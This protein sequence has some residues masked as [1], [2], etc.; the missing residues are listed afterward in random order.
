MRSNLQ[1]AVMAG[2][3]AL[4]C[5]PM[6]AANGVDRH[7][8]TPTAAD[9]PIR[10][11][12]IHWNANYTATTCC[13]PSPYRHT[14]TYMRVQIRVPD[15]MKPL[16][17]RWPKL[18]VL[19]T[20]LGVVH[21]T[22]SYERMYKLGPG[23]WVRGYGW[24]TPADEVHVTVHLPKSLVASRRLIRVGGEFTMSIANG[25]AEQ[26]AIGRI[27]DILNRRIN[28]EHVP[29]GAF[30][31]RHDAAGMHAFECSLP[32]SRTLYNVIG[33]N[34]QGEAVKLPVRGQAFSNTSLSVS[35]SEK[36]PPETLITLVYYPQ[37]VDVRLPFAFRNVPTPWADP[38]ADAARA[39]AGI[40]LPIREASR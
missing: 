32:L 8:G 25:Q 7:E 22:M 31:W 10:L 15:Q 6:S 20:D 13:G 27:S 11:W 28:I 24:N 16:A 2:A 33:K 5:C 3:M 1:F 38:S 12:S 40:V 26:A 34:D 21:D 29:D 17:L 37:A 9:F 18:G 14:S 23:P 19:E 4:L 35:L 39:D 36:L 30:M